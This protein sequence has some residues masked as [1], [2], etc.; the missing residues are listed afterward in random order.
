MGMRNTLEAL[1]AVALLR[2]FGSQHPRDRL[3]D[4]FAPVA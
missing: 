1:T 4:V 2:R 3:R